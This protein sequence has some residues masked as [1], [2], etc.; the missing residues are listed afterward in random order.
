MLPGALAVAS[1]PHADGLGRLQEV[2][3]ESPVARKTLPRAQLGM[4]ALPEG[5]KSGDELAQLLQPRAAAARVLHFH[6]PVAA[7]RGFAEAPTQ[8]RFQGAARKMLGSW[9]CLREHPDGSGS[10]GPGL[11]WKMPYEARSQRLARRNVVQRRTVL[12]VG[13]PLTF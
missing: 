4:V 6:D 12:L 13:V 2:N 8:E 9:C 10:A 1:A 7:W 3:M 11:W 5:L